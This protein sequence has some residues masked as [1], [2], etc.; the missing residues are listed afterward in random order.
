MSQA[1][2]SH[3]QSVL[4]RRA[5][6][7]SVVA[8]PLAPG[9]KL[10]H[11][12]VP[13]NHHG[14]DPLLPGLE[15]EADS[16]RTGQILAAAG[17][18]EIAVGEAAIFREGSPD[19][20][21]AHF[22]GDVCVLVSHFHPGRL[23]SSDGELAVP[24]VMNLARPD[25]IKQ[26]SLHRA[27]RTHGRRDNAVVVAGVHL[28]VEIARRVAQPA[29]HVRPG[30]KNRYGYRLIGRVF[31]MPAVNGYGIAAFAVVVGED[32]GELLERHMRGQLIPAVVVPRLR[33]ER[34]ICARAY[35]VVPLP[36]V[37]ILIL[38]M[39]GEQHLGDAFRR[40]L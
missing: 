28:A 31:S 12:K 37:Q 29:H 21:A 40:A 15:R 19:L 23:E 24:V 38:G 5:E 6:K 3:F 26:H 35:G 34:I 11:G 16:D 1:L 36:G 2:G 20:V 25:A 18:L 10:D 7:V 32:G 22:V 13:G 39:I 30:E 27:G 9:A 14:H 33:V 4:A 17:P 8:V